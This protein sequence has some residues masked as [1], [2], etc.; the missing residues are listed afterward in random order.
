VLGD[1]AQGVEETRPLRVGVVA[2]HDADVSHPDPV[3]DVHSY[4]V[5]ALALG[6]ILGQVLFLT[7]IDSAA[8]SARCS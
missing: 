1:L 8:P 7:K 5:D 6:D 4:L 3:G 2:R